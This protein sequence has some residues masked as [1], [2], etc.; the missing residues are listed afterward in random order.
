MPSGPLLKKHRC[1]GEGTGAAGGVGPRR[2][3]VSVVAW[4]F[5]PSEDEAAPQVMAQTRRRTQGQK[6]VPWMRDGRKV[7]R[8]EVE[9]VYRD[10]HHTGKRGRPPLVPTPG[11]G[12]TQVVKHRRALGQEV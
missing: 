6:D 11:V 5:A 7:Y 8:R 3:W 2:G 4:A 9:R 1:V 12:L 10:P